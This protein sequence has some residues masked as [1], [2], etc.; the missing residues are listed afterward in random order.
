MHSV[1]G[2]GVLHDFQFSLT[3]TLSRAGSKNSDILGAQIFRRG[4]GENSTAVHPVVMM[5]FFWNSAY[6]RR[7]GQ[8]GCD[9]RSMEHRID[10]AVWQ[11]DRITAFWQQKMTLDMNSR[12]DV[13]ADELSPSGLQYLPLTLRHHHHLWQNT[14]LQQCSICRQ[15]RLTHVL[16]NRKAQ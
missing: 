10:I 12:S 2:E 14:A 9:E 4:S 1:S 8:A 13:A 16:K 5:I 3:P 15:N 11:G 6:G 7:D